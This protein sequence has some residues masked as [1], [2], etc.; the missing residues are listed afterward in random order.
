[1]ATNYWLHRISHE[2]ECSYP[3]CEQ[4]ILTIGWRSYANSSLLKE[5]RR[6][7]EDA[8]HAFMEASHDTSRS[9]FSLMKFLTI[10]PG[11]QIV[12]PLYNKQFAIYRATSMAQ[13]IANLPFEKFENKKLENWNGHEVSLQNEELCTDTHVYDLGFLLKSN[14]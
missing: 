13:S 2:S 8:F 3:L 6:G 12:V 10:A 5:F 11:D 1:M 4:G 7:G 14:R 9:R